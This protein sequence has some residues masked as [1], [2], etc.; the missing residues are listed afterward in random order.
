MHKT[1]ELIQQFSK[2]ITAACVSIGAL[3]GSGWVIKAIIAPQPVLI[4]QISVPPQFEEKG[5]KSEIIVQHILDEIKYLQSIAKV[6]RRENA[7]FAKLAKQPD[8]NIQ[9]SV[10]GVSVKNIENIIQLFFNKYPKIISGEFT[11]AID[12][13]ADMKK[14]R[15]RL[16]VDNEVVSLRGVSNHEDES[17]I[18]KLMAFDLYSHFEPF[19]AALAA[20]KMGKEELV[21]ISLRK[22]LISENDEDRKYAFWLRAQISNLEQA[23][24]DFMSAISIDNNFV[25]ALIGLANLGVRERRYAEALSFIEKAIVAD[26]NNP[27]GY[28]EKGRILRAMDKKDEAL[29]NFEQACNIDK[30]FAPCHNQI[31]EIFLE[32][33]G[34]D[35]NGRKAFRDAYSKFIKAISIDK[36][37]P[38]AHS[39]AAYAAVGFG[40]LKEASLLINRAL[41][42]EPENSTHKIRYAFIIHKLGDQKSAKGLIEKIINKEPNILES[43]TLGWGS[44]SIIKS[45]MTE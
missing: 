12:T 33:S 19:R 32:K 10:G 24:S 30:S 34:S 9:A 36:L 35:E 11:I 39:N 17:D 1:L 16:R 38:W 37:H 41:M 2:T 22:M 23:K 40:D 13:P 3:F 45:I 14:I 43:K 44:R 28:H 7:I 31:G 42:L 26:K 5:F 21:R 27:A 25:P 20:Q 4:E 18:L 6:D 29:I 8:Q 15:A